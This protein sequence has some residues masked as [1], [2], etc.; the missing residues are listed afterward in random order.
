MSF[1]VFLSKS[2]RNKGKKNA[3]STGFE[4]KDVRQVMPYPAR[5]FLVILSPGGC[6]VPPPVI[7]LSDLQ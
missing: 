1:N 3:N 6:L 5:A 7:P 2:A 4:L